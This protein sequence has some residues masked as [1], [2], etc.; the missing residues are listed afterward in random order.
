VSRNWVGVDPGARYSGVCASN[1]G[2]VVTWTVVDRE[3]DPATYLVRVETEVCM[4]LAHPNFLVTGSRTI[5]GAAVAIEDVNA[6]SPHMGLARPADL[7]ALGRAVGYLQ[8][9]FPGALLIPPNKHGS[10]P[11]G[12]YPAELLTAREQANAKA[13]PLAVA[14]QSSLLRHARS[15]YDVALAAPLHARREVSLRGA[16]P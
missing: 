11:W 10:R 5:D 8:R 4:A 9:A 14:G 6:P 7:I 2:D 3:D 16:R 12:T 13:K 15:A 1:G